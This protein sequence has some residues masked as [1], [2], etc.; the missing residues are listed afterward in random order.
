[1]KLKLSGHETF[2]PRE[3]WLLRGSRWIGKQN[4][5]YPTDELGVGINMVKSIR[6]WVNAFGLDRD[7]EENLF[8]ES[9]WMSHLFKHDPDLD[10]PATAFLLHYR[11]LAEENCPTTW[12]WFFSYSDLISFDKE[13]FMRSYKDWLRDTFPNQKYSERT[14]ENDFQ[15]LTGMYADTNKTDLFYT[16]QFAD[17][18][19]IKYNS[20]TK[21]FLR[22][23]NPHINIHILL[24][25]LLQ[26]KFRHFPESSSIDLETCKHYDD[27][28][29]RV[30]RIDS[31]VLFEQWNHI[32]RTIEKKI[33]FERTAGMK[34]LL[35]NKL[36]ISELM[37][38]IY[39]TQ[40]K[41]SL[42]LF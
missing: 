14:L 19:L 2:Y 3:H 10:K 42:V 21:R 17:C 37:N 11:L 38:E 25:T 9:E 6:Y 39:Q 29:L 24:L 5:E 12:K 7:K 31:D 4:S 15:V 13:N 32:H 30:F 26:F 1:M 41:E 16:S 36:S 34:N 40:S 35:F 8:G 28:P 23:Q 18:N 33:H 27:F 20:H 22:V